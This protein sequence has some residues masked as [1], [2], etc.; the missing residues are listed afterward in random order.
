MDKRLVFVYFGF[1][2]AEFMPNPRAIRFEIM[3]LVPE[4]ELVL[5]NALDL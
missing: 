1:L 4:F 5:W 2:L 3:S